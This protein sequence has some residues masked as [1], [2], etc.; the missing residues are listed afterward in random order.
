MFSLLNIRLG[1]FLAIRQIKRSSLWT[2]LLIISVMVLTFLNLVVVS[3]I[4]VGLI[5]GSVDAER[6]QYTSDIIISSLSS[7]EYI[8]NS[9]ALITLLKSLPQVDA[10]TARYL[11]GATLEA[12]YKTR[13]N[14]NDK[15]NTAGAQITGI[16]PA[17]ENDITGV[18]KYVVEGSYLSP[19][20]YDQVLLGSLLVKQYVP[21]ENP[22]LTALRD[23]HP[24]TK[25]RI[26]VNGIVREVT[27]KGI[28]KSKVNET[29]LRA[30]MVG[31]QLKTLIG[32]DDFNVSE[33]SVRLKPG[34]DPTIIRDVLNRSGI[35]RIAKVQTYIDA[36]PKFLKDIEA[37]FALLGNM[38]S[39]IGLVVASITVF[40][41]IF[42]N[43]ITRRKFIGI[44][45]GI[46]IN[47]H[48]IEISYI[49]QS[50]FYAITG[51]IIGLFLVYGF[52]QPLIAAHPI[53]FP[54]SDGILVAPVIETG[55]RVGLLVLATIIAGYVPARM[56]V[57]KNTLD[58][59]LGRN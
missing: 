57:R 15:P 6:K 55:I 20:D 30:Y 31:S 40:I 23:V 29:G 13:T 17:A 25:I 41:V 27:V 43:A 10:Y 12:N 3:G 49:M 47:G 56:I 14:K 51:S 4:L 2:T 35:D 5:Q 32:R 48:A 46:G 1:Y 33:I 39:F 36:Q 58:S 26:K 44:L 9:P 34:V 16:D 18:A 53:D 24:G 45:K 59:I 52:L 7:K 21:V 22:G 54:F 11:S 19:T 38:I 50:I 28:I 8:E 37:T 42:I